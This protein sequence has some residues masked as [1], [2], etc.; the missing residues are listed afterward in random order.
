[1]HRKDYEAI[2]AIIKS[3]RDEHGDSDALTDVAAELGSYFRRDNSR[4]DP[5]SFWQACA[6]ETVREHR[7]AIAELA[8]NRA[9][10]RR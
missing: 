2:A 7:R 4:F 8:G 5:Q 9:R 6:S 3:T 10:E 1:M